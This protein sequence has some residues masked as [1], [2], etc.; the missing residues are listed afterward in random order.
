[1]ARDAII[2]ILVGALSSFLIGSLVLPN[3]EFLVILVSVSIVFLGTSCLTWL[4]LRR[5]KNL[6]RHVVSFL[7]GLQSAVLFDLLEYP[8]TLVRTVAVVFTF[9]AT[10]LLT[11]YLLYFSLFLIQKDEMRIRHNLREVIKRFNDAKDREKAELALLLTKIVHR[12]SYGDETVITTSLAN[13][14][15]LLAAAVYSTQRG[16]FATYLLRIEDWQKIV[17]SIVQ[18]TEALRSSAISKSRY[19]VVDEQ[20]KHLVANRD[21]FLI[22]DTLDAGSAIFFVDKAKLFQ[23]LKGIEDFAMFD[24]NLV[25]AASGDVFGKQAEDPIEI[26]IL[27]GE[28]LQKYNYYRNVLET[29]D[30][31]R[32]GSYLPEPDYRVLGDQ[33]ELEVGARENIEIYKTLGNLIFES[34]RITKG[35]NAPFKGILKHYLESALVVVRDMNRDSK[36][37]IPFYLTLNP[38]THILESK[39]KSIRA[40]SLVDTRLFWAEFFGEDYWVKNE[41]LLHSENG[42]IERIFVFSDMQ[43][44]ENSKQ[45]VLRQVGCKYRHLHEQDKLKIYICKLDKLTSH[46]ILDLAIFSDGASDICA[47]ELKTSAYPKRSP[48]SLSAFFDKHNIE[49]LS[50]AF[51]YIQDKATLVEITDLA[52]MEDELT[53]FASRVLQ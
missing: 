24:D 3:H 29:L 45:V 2:S 13:Y 47:I 33:L 51:N 9:A 16:W 22:R 19:V 10:F 41:R 36:V 38:Y 25:I 18:Y 26:K 35:D 50:N 37:V 49:R 12:I 6:G 43:D 27:T 20:E 21:E 48:E 53:T 34:K 52:K 30:E 4:I 39:V 31:I 23:H 8:S 32:I 46:Y 14:I 1:M 17:S 11:E 40:T 7:L 5:G 42:S 15:R 44:F 28:A